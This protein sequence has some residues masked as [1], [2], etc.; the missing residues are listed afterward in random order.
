LDAAAILNWEQHAQF[1]GSIGHI[2]DP[3]DRHAKPGAAGD[4]F[5]DRGGAIQNGG[6]MAESLRLMKEYLGL[7]ALDFGNWLKLRPIFRDAL[8]KAR[9]EPHA[10][11]AFC[12][13]VVYVQLELGANPDPEYG[14][15]P[16]PE[17]PW[18]QLYDGNLSHNESEAAAQLEYEESNGGHEYKMLLWFGPDVL[19]RL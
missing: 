18:N 6:D 5:Y 1:W 13:F 9:T 7:E 10:D 14:Q 3:H 15:F 8:Q 4:E 19:P 16:E 2:L 11:I 12:A 17:N